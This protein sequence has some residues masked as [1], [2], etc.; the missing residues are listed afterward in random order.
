MP[1]RRDRGAVRIDAA[2]AATAVADLGA[3]DAAGPPAATSD[4]KIGAARLIPYLWH[5]AT[6]F[7]PLEFN[8]HRPA[9]P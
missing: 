2:K 8:V 7:S 9:P 4:N 6:N 1:G 3:A 5:A